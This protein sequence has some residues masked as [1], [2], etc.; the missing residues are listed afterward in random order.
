MNTLKNILLSFGNISLSNFP[1]WEFKHKIVNWDTIKDLV[2]T[3]LEMKW[4]LIWISEDDL[5]APYWEKKLS[6]TKKLIEILANT[7]SI[8]I[9]LDNF[10]HSD[11]DW[12]FIN[13]INIFSLKTDNI[14]IVVNH[15]YTL[16]DKKKWSNI[17]DMLEI[18]KDF[19]F[20]IFSQ[21]KN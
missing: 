8:N 21:I 20:H 17:E 9:S 11:K 2:D 5:F 4:K 3:C 7:Y 15:N 10:I 13:P 16:K 12:S 18:N 14:L 19:T 1:E 6:K